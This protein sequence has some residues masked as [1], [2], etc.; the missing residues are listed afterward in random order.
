MAD[1]QMQFLEVPESKAAHSER[2]RRREEAQS[3]TD[4]GIAQLDE[5]LRKFV[6]AARSRGSV[7]AGERVVTVVRIIWS[8][9]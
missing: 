5:A 1:A 2:T 8:L 7:G 3:P 6:V 4:C 9:A